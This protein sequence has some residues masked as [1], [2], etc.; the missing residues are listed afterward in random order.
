[1]LV[2]DD[3]HWWASLWATGL[4]LPYCLIK[5]WFCARLSATETTRCH[6]NLLQKYRMQQPSWGWEW[7]N[8]HTQALL[9]RWVCWRASI[10][11][12][13]SESVI[14][15]FITLQ[16]QSAPSQM[17]IHSETQVEKFHL[18]QILGEW[19]VQLFEVQQKCASCLVLLVPIRY[20]WMHVFNTIPS[21][22]IWFMLNLP[23]ISG[24]NKQ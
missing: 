20:S 15:V 24:Y 17:T 18:R 23:F 19:Q 8:E 16:N 11:L 5:P 7:S 2:L 22:C 10:V 6:S 13:H 14:I 3:H 21:C 12:G 1:M 4:I 9:C